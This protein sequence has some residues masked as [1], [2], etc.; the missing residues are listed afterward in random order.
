M[1]NST[2]WIDLMSCANNRVGMQSVG[3]F[4]PLTDDRTHLAGS[5]PVSRKTARRSTLPS[6]P[7]NAVA[8]MTGLLV[9]VGGISW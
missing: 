9:L 1:S 2:P 8:V 3:P 5:I 7:T 4:A 6:K